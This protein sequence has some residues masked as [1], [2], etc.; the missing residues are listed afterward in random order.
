MNM[1]QTLSRNVT[2]ARGHGHRETLFQRAVFALSFLAVLPVAM[3]AAVLRWRWQ[4]WPPGA[5]GYRPMFTEAKSTAAI[6]T[7]TVFSL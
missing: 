3:T 6:I 5:H 4:P 7:A 1:N 2:T